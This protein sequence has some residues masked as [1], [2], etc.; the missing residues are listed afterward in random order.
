MS[1]TTPPWLVRKS[2]KE[3]SFVE[4]CVASWRGRFRGHARKSGRGGHR[5]AATPRPRGGASYR[6]IG[7]KSVPVTGR[8]PRA[9]PMTGR[10]RP[11]QALGAG[12]PPG[13]APL[14]G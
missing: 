8:A 5:L 4:F 3:G 1:A 9:C 2:L 10:G 12:G 11:L 7:R 14:R 13:G 6:L